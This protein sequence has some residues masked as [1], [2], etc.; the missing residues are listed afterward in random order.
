MD[1]ESG[2]LSQP[3]ISQSHACDRNKPACGDKYLL[4]LQQR[5]SLLS[6]YMG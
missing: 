2:V 4:F 1:T 6:Q 3:S 5:E